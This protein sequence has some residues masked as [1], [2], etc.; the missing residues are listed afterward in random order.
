MTNKYK[1]ALQRIAAL[2][3]Y[4]WGEADC[5]RQA[6]EIAREALAGEEDQNVPAMSER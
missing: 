6:Q 4:E 1:E 2:D 3:P 5:F